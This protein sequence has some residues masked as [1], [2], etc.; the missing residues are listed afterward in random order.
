[1]LELPPAT[2]VCFP[3]AAETFQSQFDGPGYQPLVQSLGDGAEHGLVE[4]LLADQKAVA[5]HGGA[6]LPP[7]ACLT[8]CARASGRRGEV[9][10]A[11][12]ERHD[13]AVA[14]AGSEGHLHDAGKH[15]HL[16]RQQELTLAPGADRS[17]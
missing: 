12:V 2:S 5:A 3:A 7:A 10:R 9:D 14:H 4:R 16:Q 6:P 15:R 17:S 11:S 1:M 13:P 8:S